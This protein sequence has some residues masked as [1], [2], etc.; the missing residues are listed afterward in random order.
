MDCITKDPAGA[1]LCL[2]W[3]VQTG[4]ELTQFLV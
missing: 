1:N 4:S 3:S 2:L